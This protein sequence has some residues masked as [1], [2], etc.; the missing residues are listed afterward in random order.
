MMDAVG[1]KDAARILKHLQVQVFYFVGAQDHS[2][3]DP[4]APRLCTNNFIKGIK[5]EGAMLQHL[6]EA[7][8]ELILFCCVHGLFFIG[9]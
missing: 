3:P 5:L 2:R 7:Q 6:F 8:P 4:Q 1:H 9:F